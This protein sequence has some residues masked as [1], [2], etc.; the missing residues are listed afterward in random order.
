MYG[1]RYAVA[2]KEAS[3]VRPVQTCVGP[4]RWPIVESRRYEFPDLPLCN[5]SPPPTSP[6]MIE[7]TSMSLASSAA[8]LAGTQRYL[9][10][11]FGFR[12]KTLSL[13]EVPLLAN[14]FPVAT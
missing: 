8:W 10:D 3:L 9:T 11:R 14:P 7:P 4:W 1:A 5:T 13:S 6:G 12:T 2:P